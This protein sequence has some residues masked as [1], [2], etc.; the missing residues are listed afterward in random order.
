MEQSNKPIWYRFPLDLSF[1]KD[2]EL[3]LEERV[4]NSFYDARLDSI[5]GWRPDFNYEGDMIGV[6]IY[7]SSGDEIFT[8]I[9][10]VDLRAMLG[11]EPIK[12]KK[13]EGI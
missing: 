4:I 12:L 8:K 2:K 5:M 9:N 11:Y 10:P 7:F 3:G 13:S 1:N 6:M